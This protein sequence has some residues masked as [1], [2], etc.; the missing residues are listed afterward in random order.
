MNIEGSFVVLTNIYGYNN[1][2][3]NRLLLSEI[4]EAV[5]QYK[6]CYRTNLILFGGDF[7]IA[8]DDWLDRSPSKFTN[9]HFNTMFLDFCNTRSL[10]DIWRNKN[11]NVRQFS[12]LKPYGSY[13]SRIDLWLSTLEVAEYVSEVFISSA[14][15]TDHCLLYLDLKPETNI[16]RRNVHWK[17]NA[18][19]LKSEEYCNIIKDLLRLNLIQQS[20]V[21]AV[22]GNFLSLRSG[23][24][25]L[26]LGKKEAK[27]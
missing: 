22:G 26:I 5:T 23:K 18:D 17:F 20:G 10:I 21:I 19:L 4:S 6:E 2:N 13:K 27:K 7:N 14:P 11:L 8:P 1:T 12:W 25:L 9:H 24:F 16:N 15:L 3:Q